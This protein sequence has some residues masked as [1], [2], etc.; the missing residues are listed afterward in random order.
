MKYCLASSWKDDHVAGSPISPLRAGS[1]TF[2]MIGA[3]GD[4][5][6]FPSNRFAAI[7]YLHFS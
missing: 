7:L 3:A 4:Q 5:D 1:P 2:P 6:L